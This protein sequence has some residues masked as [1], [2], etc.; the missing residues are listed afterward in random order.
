MLRHR[1]TCKLITDRLILRKYRMSDAEDMFKNWACDPNVCE[2]MAW[3]PHDSI[4][5]T[6]KKINEWTA[7]YADDRVYHWVIEFDGRA[8]GDI[9]VR[10][11]SEKNMW[12]DVGYC[13]SGKY[14]GRGFAPEALF[15]VMEFLFERVG[16]NRI[17]AWHEAKNRASGR[18]MEKCGMTLEGTA[19]KKD[20]RYDGKFSDMKMYGI[21]REEFAPN[22]SVRTAAKTYAE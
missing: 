4:E 5:T 22:K 16:F 18:V 20:L 15:A 3:R 21:L 7:E 10:T 13:I 11:M 12:C 17:G 14:W 8:I 2:Y 9:A 19:R 1:G 6:V